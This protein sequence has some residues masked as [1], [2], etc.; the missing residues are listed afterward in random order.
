M[1]AYYETGEI[2]AEAPGEETPGTDPPGEET[3]GTDPPGEETPG[4]DPPGEETPGTE[5]PGKETPGTDPPGEE[6]PGTDPPGTEAPEDVT[7]EPVHNE[8]ETTGEKLPDTA[9]STYNTLLIGAIVLITGAIAFLIVR[10][11]TNA[12]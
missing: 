10:R 11:K 12:E 1:K 2:P 3:P 4:T 9:T 7:V 8:K 6:T 5:T